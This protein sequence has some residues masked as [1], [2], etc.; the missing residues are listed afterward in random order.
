MEDY[1]KGPDD[2]NLYGIASL[3]VFGKMYKKT[4]L[5][6]KVSLGLAGS[7]VIYI[8]FHEASYALVYPFKK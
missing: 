3:W 1:T 7:D 4:E 2:D 6:I 5:Y 8:S